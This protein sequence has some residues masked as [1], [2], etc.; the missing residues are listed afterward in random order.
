L[1]RHGDLRSP[2]GRLVELHSKSLPRH[3]PHLDVIAIT[4]RKQRTGTP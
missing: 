2:A 1:A 3:P 4:G